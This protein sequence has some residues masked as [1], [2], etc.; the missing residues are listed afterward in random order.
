[1]P[2]PPCPVRNRVRGSHVAPQAR[3]LDGRH[4]PHRLPA[5]AVNGIAVAIG[6]GCVHLVFAAIGG[7][8]AAQIAGT[9]AVCASLADLYDKGDGIIP[10]PVRARE[11]FRRACKGGHEES[12]ARL[13]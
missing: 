11:L 5:Y 12:C 9:G 6:V 7:G 8:A 3:S 2:H 13:R 1:M 4:L 10:D